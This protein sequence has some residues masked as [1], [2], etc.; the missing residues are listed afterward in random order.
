MLCVA[1]T[2][3]LLNLNTVNF[4][5][6][7]LVYVGSLAMSCHVLNIGYMEQNIVVHVSD[8]VWK[9]FLHKA[10]QTDFTFHSLVISS[11]GMPSFRTFH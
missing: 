7:P 6:T 11:M 1:T 10:C 9:R 3:A 2:L 5:S 8:A 4:L